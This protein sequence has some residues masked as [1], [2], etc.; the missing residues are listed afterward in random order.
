MTADYQMM[1][2]TRLICPSWLPDTSK[3][4]MDFLESSFFKSSH[5]K[6]PSPAEVRALGS[7]GRGRTIVRFEEMNLLVKYG[8]KINVDEAV[9]MWAIKK[10]LG[11]EVPVPEVYGWRVVEGHVFIYMELIQGETMKERWDSLSNSDRVAVCG[12][13]HQIFASLRQVQQKPDDTFIGELSK[14]PEY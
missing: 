11:N 12:H 9:C 4:E 3:S 14:V 10:V 2:E 8:E 6:L 1:S 5:H 7:A 13:L